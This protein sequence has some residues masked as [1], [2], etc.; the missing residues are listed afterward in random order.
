MSE[1]SRVGIKQCRK[2]IDNLTENGSSS[3]IYHWPNFRLSF[4][5]L[6]SACSTDFCNGD[7]I[8]LICV[9]FPSMKEG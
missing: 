6:T 9:T 3:R 4:I 7:D 8:K 2:L 1:S 5:F